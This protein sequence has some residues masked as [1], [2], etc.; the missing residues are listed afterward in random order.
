MAITEKWYNLYVNLYQKLQSKGNI[1]HTCLV[2]YAIVC[3]LKSIYSN[4][5][6]DIKPHKQIIVLLMI[7]P[8][9]LFKLRYIAVPWLSKPTLQSGVQR[10]TMCLFEQQQLAN[11]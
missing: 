8:V 10:Q 2:E 3:K 6:F 1:T 5:V 9:C 4:N 7:L 11:G